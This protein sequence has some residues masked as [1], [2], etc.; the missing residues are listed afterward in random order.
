M[1]R[2]Q[3]ELHCQIAQHMPSPT[4]ARRQIGWMNKITLGLQPQD[5]YSVN[6]VTEGIEALA[7]TRVGVRPTGALAAQGIVQ[8]AQV[9]IFGLPPE[10]LSSIQNS[11]LHADI[12]RPP[13]QFRPSS[14]T[15]RCMNNFGCASCCERASQQNASVC[16]G[17]SRSMLN[18]S[19]SWMAILQTTR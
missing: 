9:T 11:L 10:Y 2:S 12:C 8:N 1:R 6:S 18:P 14:R 4:T 17:S 3:M 5:D 7:V 13:L 16:S 15:P 19:V